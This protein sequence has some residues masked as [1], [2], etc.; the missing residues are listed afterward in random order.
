MHDVY[1]NLPNLR[2]K[3]LSGVYGGVVDYN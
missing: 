3:G 1:E 2:C